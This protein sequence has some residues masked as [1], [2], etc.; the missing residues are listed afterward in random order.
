MLVNVNVS[1]SSQRIQPQKLFKL[2]QDIKSKKK[3]GKILSKDEV[4]SLL[5]NWDTIEKKGNKRKL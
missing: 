1:K 4:D 2:P 3:K 5:E